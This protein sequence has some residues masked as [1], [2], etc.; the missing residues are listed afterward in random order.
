MEHFDSGFQ[1]KSMNTDDGVFHG[2]GSVF[3][4]IDSHGDI[5][6]KGAFNDSIAE[7]KSTGR[8][9]AMLLMH[10]TGPLTDDQLPIGIWTGMHEDDTGLHLVG[11]LAVNTHRG[12]DLNALMK[13]E[14]RPALDGLSIGYRPQRFT[15][16][17]RTSTA[18][19]TLHSVKLVEV[20]LV[21][22]PSNK[23]ATVR[24]MKQ[25]TFYH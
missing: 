1:L 23:L 14:P 13:M 22:S 6:A 10:A 21:T 8:W 3:G 5:V 2:Y 19:R 4:N 24:G 12:H 20:S 16:H 11:K 7:A 9:P 15:V 18:R 25:G 17:G